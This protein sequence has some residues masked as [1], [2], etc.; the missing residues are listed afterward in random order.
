MDQLSHLSPAFPPQVVAQ[1]NFG[2]LIAPMP[3]MNKLEYFAI[4]LL[5]AFIELGTKHKLSDK[6]VPVTPVQAAIQAAKQL[7]TELEKT[8]ENETD[9]TAIVKHLD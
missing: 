5:P 7:L 9:Q 6:G 3:G 2:R 1:D 8:K 4:Q